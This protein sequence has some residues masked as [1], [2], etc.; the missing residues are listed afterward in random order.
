MDQGRH[1][2][3]KRQPA[4]Q[5]RRPTL[6]AR[7]GVHYPAQLGLSDSNRSIT[8]YVEGINPSAAQNDGLLQVT[9]GGGGAGTTGDPTDPPK[10]GLRHRHHGEGRPRGRLNNRDGTIDANDEKGKADTVDYTKPTGA[11]VIADLSDSQGNGTVNAMNNVI[12]TAQETANFAKL[13]VAKTVLPKGWGASIEVEDQGSKDVHIY[14]DTKLKSKA[15]IGPGPPLK[16]AQEDTVPSKYDLTA[17][18]IAALATGDLTFYVEGINPGREVVI[19]LNFT[20]NNNA[21]QPKLDDKVHMLV[22]PLIF[23]PNTQAAQ[24]V[25]YSDWGAHDSL[26]T[27][28]FTKAAGSLA[29]KANVKEIHT[30]DSGFVQDPFAFTYQRVTG[31]NG[32]TITLPTVLQRCRSRARTSSSRPMRKRTC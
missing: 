15:V 1:D 8:L 18:D 25:Y 29:G 13:V 20:D 19:D 30:G 14:K 28:A 23:L 24:K 9:L 16:P 17:A 5:R 3:P 6:R 26:F 10:E 7:R 11:V 4:R 12:T 22:A 21:D 31:A 2:R 32:K 27:D